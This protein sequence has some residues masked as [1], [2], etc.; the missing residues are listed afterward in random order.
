MVRQAIEQALKGPEMIYISL[1]IDVL[2][3]GFAPGCT[4]PEP[5][6]MTQ[7]TGCAPFS[8]SFRPPT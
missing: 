5:G 3:P 8:D 6:G 1:D 2:E 7:A 4:N